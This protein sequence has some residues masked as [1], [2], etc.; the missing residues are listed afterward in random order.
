M[1]ERETDSRRGELAFEQCYRAHRGDV[2]RWCLRYGAGREDWA[3]DLAHDVFLR[4]HAH[5]P[6]LRRP[7]ELAPWLYRV[8]ANLALN[9]LR[10]EQSVVGKLARFF[11]LTPEYAPGPDAAHVRRQAVLATLRGLP[12]RERVVLCLKVIDGKSQ[13]EI[14]DTLGMSEGNVS[15]IA[16]RA[17]DLVR[18]SGWESDD[19]P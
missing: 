17:W 8:T 2:F 9:R 1:T 12:A 13:K 7:E 4:L 18:A 5:L 14:A 15:K 19:A 16:T 10:D 6:S 11:A 3:E